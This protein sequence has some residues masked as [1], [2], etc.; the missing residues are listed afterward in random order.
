[1]STK[2]QK[3]LITLY[4]N[5]KDLYKKWSNP[6]VNLQSLPVVSENSIS[7]LHLNADYNKKSVNLVTMK[8][9]INF[10]CLP[11]VVDICCWHDRN[12]FTNQPI[13][14]PIQYIP[15]FTDKN[16][17]TTN[18]YYLTHGVFCSF[19]CALAYLKDNK[20]QPLLSNSL[21]LLNHLHV[22]LFGVDLNLNK[23]AQPWQTLKEY[24]GIYNI[25]EFRSNNNKSEL[26][27]SVFKRP[28][29]VSVGSYIKENKCGCIY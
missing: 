14:L 10:G 29:C 25:E 11:P 2:K 27:Q 21:M 13:G 17:A 6:S 12:K 9:Y 8:D 1:M 23:V 20:H 24:G 16:N 7:Y 19:E 15:E 22:K 28:Y 18:D 5:A 26:I 4:I 3:K